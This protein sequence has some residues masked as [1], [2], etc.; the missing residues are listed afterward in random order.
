MM[1]P[2]VDIGAA[3]PLTS[4]IDSRSPKPMS[5][6]FSSICLISSDARSG[7]GCSG[8][9]QTLA[10]PLMALRYQREKSG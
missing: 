8:A 1:K 2:L 4:I 5:T 10:T 3:N 6:P 9:P 7:A